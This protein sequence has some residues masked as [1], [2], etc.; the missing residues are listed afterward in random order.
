MSP[1]R[2]RALSR[3][4]FTLIELLV[5]IAI[6]AILIGLLLPAVQKVRDAAARIKCANNLKQIGLA[7][8]NHHDVIGT[9]P[10]GHVE[11]CP[12]GT[13]KGTET[14]CTYYTNWAIAILPYIEQ[15]NLFATYQDFPTPNY[16]PGYLQ[17]KDFS[18]QSVP[19]YMCPSDTRAN[20]MLA[21]ETLAPNGAGNGSGTFQYRSSSYKGMTG[22]GDYSSTNTFGGYWDEVQ[23]AQNAHPN[24]MGVFHGDGYSGLGPSRINDIIDGTSNTVM[25]GER[26]MRN[27]FTRGPFWADSFNLYTLGAV[28]PPNNANMLMTLS[29]DYDKCTSSV[30]A[31]GTGNSNYCKYGWGSL[32]AGGNMNW[33]FGDGSVRG[34]T[35]NIDLNILGALSTISGGEVIPNF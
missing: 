5:V 8:H 26:L 24:G 12:S 31:G 29:P 19:I 14:G 9:F 20:K 23:T 34:I 17:N 35:Q 3:C 18:A 30:S 33:L 6:I 16:M 4:G 7:L 22:I 10:S 13:G 25:V 2:S 1:S 11:Q 32:H 28:Y 15:G 27:H 21:P